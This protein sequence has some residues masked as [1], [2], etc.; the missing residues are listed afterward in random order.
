M[1]LQR[2]LAAV[3]VTALL[4]SGCASLGF[5]KSE[6]LTPPKASGIRAEV[7]KLIETDAGG[8]YSLIYPTD[9][10][11]KS[12]LFLHDVNNDGIVDY[13]V[14]DFGSDPDSAENDVE[15]GSVVFSSDVFT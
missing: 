14:V 9:G 8:A 13:E 6:I 3:I 1:R 2:I 10:A 4:L 5:G 11:N 12:G 15:R 7:Q